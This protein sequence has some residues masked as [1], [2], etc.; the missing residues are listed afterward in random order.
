MPVAI[1]FCMMH[2]GVPVRVTRPMIPYPGRLGLTRSSFFARYF[3]GS[4]GLRFVRLLF[5]ITGWY[6]HNRY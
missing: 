2:A 3:P 5:L 6:V 1:F 4:L